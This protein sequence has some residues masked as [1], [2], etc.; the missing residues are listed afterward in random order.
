MDSS[1]V[2]EEVTSRTGGGPIGFLKGRWLSFFYLLVLLVA[3]LVFFHKIL[4]TDQ[5]IYTGDVELDSYWRVFYAQAIKSGH[6]PLWNPYEFSGYPFMAGIENA[7]FYPLNLLFLT[8]PVERA[9]NYSVILHFFLAGSLMYLFL[10]TLRLGRAAA[11]LGGCVFAFNGFWLGRSISC[12]AWLPLILLFLE[13]GIRK[14]RSARRRHSGFGASATYFILAG[15]AYAVQIF[16]GVVQF[17][18]YSGVAIGIY[19]FFRFFSVAKERSR[20]RK[21]RMVLSF[22]LACAVAFLLTSIQLVPTYEL[23]QHSTRVKA[24]YEEMAAESLPPENLLTFF[25][26]EVFG[27][28][29]TTPYWGRGTFNELYAYLGI[30]PLVLAVVAILFVRGKGLPVYLL[31]G[32]LGLLCALGRFTPFYKFFYLHFPGASSFRI[33]A[34]FLYLLVFSISALAAY[35]A[36]F[37]LTHFRDEAC[38]KWMSRLG[39]GLI[40]IAASLLAFLL[41]LKVSGGS[42]SRLWRGILGLRKSTQ[43]ETIEAPYA[44]FQYQKPDATQPLFRAKSFATAVKG[45][46]A[47]ALLLSASGFLCLGLGADRVRLKKSVFPALMLGLVLF[48]LWFFHS[49]LVFTVN[50]QENRWSEEIVTS[51]KQDKSLFRIATFTPR[52]DDLQRGMKHK[53][54]NVGGERPLILTH[55]QEFFNAN[56][57]RPLDLIQ[58]HIHPEKATPLLDLLNVKYLL[59]QRPRFLQSGEDY[60]LEINEDFLPRAFIVHRAVYLPER[61]ILLGTLSREDFPGQDMVLFQG[62][63]KEITY[64][65]SPEPERCQITT[66]EINRVVVD[67][68]LGSPGY[69]ILSETFYPGWEAYV[70]RKKSEIIRADYVLR[71]VALEKG[72]HRVEFVFRPTS[73]YIGATIS[74]ITLCA[75]VAFFL[76]KALMRKPRT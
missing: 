15:V 2:N 12:M 66:Y 6:F 20:A 67:V 40:L 26:P 69:L 10:R 71:A 32:G 54:S 21:V 72:E 29:I 56:N 17:A 8:M 34:K 65:T 46:L 47:L 22:L 70:N 28:S 39:L 5:T 53:I 41:V 42:D 35:G 44:L 68:F 45:G 38:R 63:G 51:L 62:P 50:M 64:E 52:A 30:L 76:I 61:S 60:R 59:E 73:F 9:A 48:D 1:S 19:F 25:I 43:A 74:G 23:A 4:T 33:P 57:G 49:K 13:K 31:I 14:E 58:D 11:L 3:T 55:Y 75:L 36:D 24:S 37:L 27:N 7:V 16:A 18:F